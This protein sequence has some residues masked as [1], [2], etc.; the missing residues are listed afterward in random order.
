VRNDSFESKSG[1]R[2]DEISLWIQWHS[3]LRHYATSRKVMGL[4]P[5]RRILAMVDSATNRNEYR[6]Y[7]LWGIQAVGA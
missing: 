4:I 3:W 7:F 1:K 5:F 2:K 6:V